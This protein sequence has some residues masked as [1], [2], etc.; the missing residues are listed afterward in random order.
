MS[1]TSGAKNFHYPEKTSGSRVAKKLR[2]EANKLT[3]SQR[4]NLFKRGMQI[5]YGGTGTTE[6][7]RAR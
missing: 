1:Q 7:T 2:S 5:I 6:A 4:E 3:E